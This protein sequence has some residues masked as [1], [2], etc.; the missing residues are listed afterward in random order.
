MR[1]KKGFTLIELMIV[2]SVIGILGM[3]I[4]PNVGSVKTQSKNQSAATNVMLVRSFIENRGARDAIALNTALLAGRS[5][6]E[7]MGEILNSLK[8]DMTQV[9]SGSNALQNPFNNT[10]SINYSHQDVRLNNP[11]SAS[12]VLGYS[13]DVNSVLPTDNST[14]S[15]ALPKDKSFAGNVVVIMYKTG[16]VL[17]G[18]DSNGDIININIIKNPPI[19]PV[20]QSGIGGGNGGLPGGINDGGTTP[21]GILANIGDVVTYIKSI[22]TEKI[23]IGAPLGQIWDVMKSPLDGELRAQFTPGNTSKNIVNP[24]NNSDNIGIQYSSN[25]TGNYSIISVHN[26]DNIT[27]EDTAF[28]NKPGT[29]IVY[30]TSNPA[31]YVV[32]GVDQDGKNVGYTT[33]TLSTMVTPEMTQAL[34]NNVTMVYNILKT[35]INT[36]AVGNQG[37]MS[38]AA[39]N[40]LKNLNISNAYWP[41]WNKIGNFDSDSFTKGY[42]LMVSGWNMEGAGYRDFK[43]SVA[44]NVLKD[45]TGYEIFGID[46]TGNRYAYIKA[47]R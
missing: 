25:I 46:Y 41:A 38:T 35:N 30:V 15:S 33:I 24:Y 8:S 20:V 1:V 29:V 40:A 16:Y 13:A 36:I 12:V 26:A 4:V 45:G 27:T 43:G 34:A 10:T 23:L 44:V 21:T 39:Y 22:T 31:G 9:F 37:A 17:Y 6:S 47:V 14:V 18:M 19:P 5:Y 28:S 32:Y 42:A 7:A 11:D 2:I 3:V